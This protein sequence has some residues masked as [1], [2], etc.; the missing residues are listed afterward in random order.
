MSALN[1]MRTFN[2]IPN[3][4]KATITHVPFYKDIC[5][6]LNSHNAYVRLWQAT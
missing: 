6:L 1:K 2:N 5:M 4:R 3:Y